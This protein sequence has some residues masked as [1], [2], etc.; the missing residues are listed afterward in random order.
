MCIRCS[1]VNVSLISGVAEQR[2]VA[3]LVK[4]HTHTACLD[5]FVREHSKRCL[6]GVARI[7]RPVSSE[8]TPLWQ[9]QRSAAAAAAAADPQD[10]L[11]R[12]WG[13]QGPEQKL[14]QDSMSED[15]R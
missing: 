14:G 13:R 8:H 4:Q 9:Q 2:L 6:A 10:G 7:C 1:P 12:T 5:G 11:A 3:G 15:E